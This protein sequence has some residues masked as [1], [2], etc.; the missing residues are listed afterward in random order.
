MLSW[1]QFGGDGK[2]GIEEATC[3]LA[4]IHNFFSYF[5]NR[6]QVPL[7]L[8]GISIVQLLLY[9]IFAVGKE[10]ECRGY[11]SCQGVRCLIVPSSRMGGAK[12]NYV[13]ASDL[14]PVT[15]LEFTTAA[16]RTRLIPSRF[17]ESFLQLCV[18]G[19]KHQH[20]LSRSAIAPQQLGHDAHQLIDV[21]K[22]RFVACTQIIQPW[23]T[24]RRL[25]EAVLGTLAVT[26]ETHLALAAVAR[27]RVALVHPKLPLLV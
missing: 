24:I 20:H 4:I 25:D 2:H 18:F 21:C 8:S 5:L 26:G 15:L 1:S 22:E 17:G 11:G 19:C 14:F 7:N 3:L 10:W 12:C 16:T 23:L 13:W 6:E 27:Q 9:V